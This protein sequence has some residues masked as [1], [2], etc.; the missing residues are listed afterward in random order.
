[1]RTSWLG[2]RDRG[3]LGLLPSRSYRSKNN[4]ILDDQTYRLLFVTCIIAREI[5]LSVDRSIIRHLLPS[6][7]LY[8]FL[9]LT[10]FL[11]PARACV[12]MFACACRTCARAFAV[13]I[14]CACVF[15]FVHTCAFTSRVRIYIHSCACVP[16]FAYVCVQ[17]CIRVRRDSCASRACRHLYCQCCRPAGAPPAQWT[18]EHF[19]LSARSSSRRLFPPANLDFHVSSHRNSYG[20]PPRSSLGAARASPRS[21]SVAMFTCHPPRRPVSPRFLC[22]CNYS[23]PCSITE[24]QFRSDY[25]SSCWT[26]PFITSPRRPS[27]INGR[28]PPATQSVYTINPFLRFLCSPMFFAPLCTILAESFHCVPVS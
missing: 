27:R 7:H 16:E 10:F 5:T 26:A 8:L 13:S 2:C 14:P 17:M 22:S 20:D 21:N 15:T 25:Y 12:F 6:D 1:M 28:R 23:R 18:R 4:S 19:R 11:S 24:K 9:S 3:V